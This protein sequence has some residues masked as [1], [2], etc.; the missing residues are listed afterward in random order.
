ML[1]RILRNLESS[2]APAIE[3]LG[4]PGAYSYRR[5]GSAVARLQR[6]LADRAARLGKDRLRVGLFMPNGPEWVCADLALLFGGHLEVPVPLEFTS[7]QARALLHGADLCLVDGSGAHAP[8]LACVP[9]S[10]RVLVRMPMAGGTAEPPTWTGDPDRG[11]LLVKAI[12][13]S[14]TT[15]SPK[16]VLLSDRAIQAKV[17]TLRPLIGEP[18]L[19]RYFSLVPLSLLIEQICGIYLPLSTGGTLVLLAMDERPL[20]G[21]GPPASHYLPFLAEARATFLAL[22]PSMVEAV[23]KAASHCPEMPAA[24]LSRTLFGRDVP[25]L[26]ACGGAPVAVGTLETLAARG[27]P[28]LEGYG[29]SENASVVSW[30]LPGRCKLGTVGRPLPDCE[31]ALAEDGELLLHSQT[32][33]EGYLGADPGS[34]RVGPDGFLATG[35]LAEIDDEGFLRILGRKKNIFINDSGRKVSAE[36][37][38]AEL[39]AKPEI[40]AAVVFGDRQAFPVALLVP[41]AQVSPEAVLRAVREANVEL[42][43]YARVRNFAALAMTEDIQGRYFTVTGR[44]R[45]DQIA[46]AFSQVLRGLAGSTHTDL[47]YGGTP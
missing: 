27:I 25:P 20:T 42:P 43:D 3:V 39:C 23:H 29:L 17:D 46:A 47:S 36:W 18:N 40:T 26:V 37:I 38:E 6:Q 14:G 7:S 9:R 22:P 33:M 12:H 2:D 16:G 45:R 1:E 15:S 31:V 5:L 19:R 8:Q 35:D 24:S 11:R 13:T 30:N 21:G 34:C 4:T 10:R 41:R 44:P 32:L 28:V